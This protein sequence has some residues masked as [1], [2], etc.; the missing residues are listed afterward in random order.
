MVIVTTGAVVV[1]VVLEDM[2]EAVV[3]LFI[4]A[5]SLPANNAKPVPYVKLSLAV[6]GPG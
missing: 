5:T 1:V 6:D 2:L 4:F 3:L